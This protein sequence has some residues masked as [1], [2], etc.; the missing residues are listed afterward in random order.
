MPTA[1]AQ[2]VDVELAAYDLTDAERNSVSAKVTKL[3]EEGY[4]PDQ[5]VVIAIQK[6]A[7]KKAKRA[8]SVEPEPLP[9]T[10]RAS[11]A[12]DG[13]IVVAGVPVFAE[14]K[15][16]QFGVEL[17]YDREWLDAALA[18]DRKLRADGYK[19]PM[20]FGH[21]EVALERER[22]GHFVLDEVRICLYDDKPTAVLFGSLVFKSKAKLERAMADFPYRSVEIS[23]EKPNE[24]NSLAL[25]SSEAPYF[26]F[27][28]L[29]SLAFSALPGNALGFAWRNKMALHKDS[30][31][32]PA[33]QAKPDPPP[34]P[35]GN[36]AV[37]TA[38]P[39]SEQPKA[40]DQDD[41]QPEAPAEEP[42][43]SDPVEFAKIV[44]DKI[45]T[46]L[47]FVAQ[48][49]KMQSKVNSGEELTDA[50]SETPDTKNGV[51][52]KRERPPIVAATATV[53]AKSGAN[54]KLEGEVEALRSRLAKAERDRADDTL[55]S[56]LKKALS[57]YQ[58]A[59]F[60]ARLEAHLAAGT[61][62]QWAEGIQLT[63]PPARRNEA[64]LD[65]ADPPEVAKYSERGPEVLAEA[66]RLY[67]LYQQASPKSITRSHKPEV[68]LAA[69][70]EI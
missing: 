64:P 14:N 36:G 60:E 43:T 27:P 42:K 3:R 51:A 49:L 7:P 29:E 4:E 47:G 69:N 21:H 48:M 24:I 26:R 17:N 2:D 11:V 1:F 19:A 57:S 18:A 33:N 61:A 50:G 65:S 63:A 16:T 32:L 6:C 28:N 44:M 9:T 66:R 10:Y 70:L 34:P 31:A 68:F 38:E 15:R 40:G 62:R 22:A 67:A 8:A 54:A 23:H 37:A 30:P 55:R 20:H 52:P 41:E 39:E 45:D 58:I 59:N 5:A 35:N 13:S 46:L 56:E 53:D 12:P 25:L